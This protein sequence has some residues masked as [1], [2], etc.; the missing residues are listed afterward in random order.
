MWK[1]VVMRCTTEAG[2]KTSG[3]ELQGVD[4]FKC[5]GSTVV[6]DEEVKMEVGAIVMK[7]GKILGGMNKLFENRPQ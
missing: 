5:L 3:E 1:T 4:C 6:V 2:D 7:A